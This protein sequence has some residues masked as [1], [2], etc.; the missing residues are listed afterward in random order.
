M[1]T[2]STDLDN[3]QL[4][5]QDAG[6]IWPRAEL[7]LYYNTAYRQL[8]AQSHATRD[9]AILTVPPRH[10]M[11]YTHDWERRHVLGG[12]ARKWT[13]PSMRREYA[14]LWG[15]EQAVGQ[16]PQAAHTMVTHLWETV[17]VSGIVDAYTRFALPKP[18]ERIA[19]MWFDHE[20]MEALSVRELDT[21]WTA[22]YR[23]QG[24]L[25]FWAPGL[26]TAKSVEVYETPRVDGQVYEQTA[27]FGLPRTLTGDR[28]ST[29]QVTRPIDNSYAYTSAGDAE[30]LTWKSTMFAPQSAYTDAGDIGGYYD[31]AADLPATFLPTY[32]WTLTSNRHDRKCTYTWE[33]GAGTETEPGVGR[34]GQ[35]SWEAAHGATVPPAQQQA[36]GVG[37]LTGLGWRCTQPVADGFDCTY[38]W[39]AEMQNGQTSGFTTSP[40]I[41]TYSWEVQHGAQALTFAVG[42]IRQLESADRHYWPQGAWG[43][44]LGTI[45]AW[46][47]SVGN[48][49]LWQVLSPDA[50]LLEPD[51]PSMVP[52]QLQ[53]Y[54]TYSVLAQAY[55][56]QGEG[57]DGALAGHWEQRWLRG[58]R[59]L[60]RLGDAAHADRHWQRTP[61]QRRLSRKPHAPLMPTTFPAI[62]V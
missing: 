32:Q 18:H 24:D 16:T 15:V 7:L 34:R 33:A 9:F 37:I 50:P 62:E 30:A 14:N 5:L 20:L 38:A 53:K 45:R 1:P 58:I 27:L 36:V 42:S 17:Y 12:T 25:F 6:A 11:V 54:L 57:F 2:V 40:T 29:P 59:L 46:G 48:I 44:L 56:R 43:A 49:L 28:T 41:G 47:S 39:E 51:T 23:Q 10:T 61:T 13:Y 35:F 55:N 31:A 60:R 3:V 26:T 52:P 21:S 8:L 19:A 22:W 4:L